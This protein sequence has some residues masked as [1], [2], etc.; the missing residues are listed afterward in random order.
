MVDV[1]LSTGDTMNKKIRNAQ[2]DQYNYILGIEYHTHYSY[3]YLST[4]VGE[5]EVTS[6][7]VNVRTRDNVV[8]GEV[9]LVRLQERLKELRDT[10]VLEDT[11]AF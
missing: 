4:V 1:D 7:T 2:L 11:G 8:H 9:T 10:R 5:K 6:Q 3:Y